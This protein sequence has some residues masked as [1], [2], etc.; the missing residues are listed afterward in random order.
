MLGCL[1]LRRGDG[2]GSIRAGERYMLD[3]EY[4]GA[5]VRERRVDY[6]PFIVLHIR[7][8]TLNDAPPVWRRSV[9]FSFMARKVSNFH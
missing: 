9:F 6:F 1:R 3:Q 8:E 4:M 2:F 7:I 5:C